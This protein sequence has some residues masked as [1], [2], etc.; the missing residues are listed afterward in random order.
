MS[1]YRLGRHNRQLIYWQ[2]GT[3]P[4]DTDPLVLVATDWPTAAPTVDALNA[5]LGKADQRQ[6]GLPPTDEVVALVSELANVERRLRALSQVQAHDTMIR[7]M[8]SKI[9]N[10][11]FDRR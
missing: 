4:A 5:S 2:P 10:L 9:V 8:V 11:C 3:K 7:T 6:H 1:S